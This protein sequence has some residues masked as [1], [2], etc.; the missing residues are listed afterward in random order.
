MET[1][2]FAD[3]AP[4]AVAMDAPADRCARDRETDPR[5]G[6]AVGDP[7][8][9]ENASV[10]APDFWVAEYMPELTR[11]DQAVTARKAE[12]SGGPLRLRG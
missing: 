5:M 7:G 6:K 3:T 4:D 9:H 2:L 10:G 12:T 8:E 1:E 11:M